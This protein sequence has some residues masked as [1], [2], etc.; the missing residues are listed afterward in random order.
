MD[1]KQD[2]G[3][4]H[5]TTPTPPPPLTH[6]PNFPS[7]HDEGDR[8]SSIDLIQSPQLDAYSVYAPSPSPSVASIHSVHS[9]QSH[10]SH[11]SLHS[12]HFG[13]TFIDSSIPTYHGPQRTFAGFVGSAPIITSPT[14]PDPPFNVSPV[15]P[16]ANASFPQPFIPAP[17]RV[18]VSSIASSHRSMDWSDAHGTP[19]H[20]HPM[21]IQI[22]RENSIHEDMMGSMTPDRMHGHTPDSMKKGQRLDGMESPPAWAEMKTKAGKDRKR[23]PLACIACRRKKIRCSGQKPACKHCLRS[24]VPCVYKVNTR[25]ANPRTDYMAMLDKRLKRMEER[26]VKSIP[27]DHEAASIPRAVLKPTAHSSNSKSPK[28]SKKRAAEDAFGTTHE[29]DGWSKSEP[30]GISYPKVIRIEGV[31]ES[32]MLIEGAAYLPSKDLQIHLAETYFDY[33]YAQSYPLLH[34]PTFMRNLQAGLVPPVLILAVCAVSARFSNHPQLR[35]EPAFL[36]GEEWAAPARE[37]SMKHYDYSNITILTVYLLLG[38]HEFGTCQGG[39][40]WMFGGMA[41]RMALMMQ[42][43]NGGDGYKLRKSDGKERDSR[44]SNTDR[45]NRRRVMWSCFLMDRFTSSGSDRPICFPEEAITVPLPIRDSFYLME[46]EG[47]TETLNGKEAS[48]N[49]SVEPS[50]NCLRAAREKHLGISAHLIR[51]VAIWGRLVNYLNLGGKAREKIPIWNSSSRFQELAQAVNNFIF[52]EELNWNQE[53]L[54]THRAEKVDNQFVLLHIVYQH[55][56]LFLHRFAIPGYGTP[57][58]RGIPQPFLAESQRTAL[59]AANEVSYLVQQAMIS[60]VTAPF[61]GYAAFYS[62]TVHVQGVF[63]KNAQVAERSRK[64]LGTN[65]KFLTQMKRWWGMFH[66]V[67][68][69]LK[70]L[71]RKHV[72]A[73]SSRSGDAP[74]SLDP[75]ER[76]NSTIFQYGD[77]FDRYPNG[78][79]NAE[80]EISGYS[81]E[82]NGINPDLLASEERGNATVQEFFNKFE[83]GNMTIK[84]DSAGCQRMIK[85]GRTDA[86]GK[87]N[88]RPKLTM[89]TNILDLPTHNGTHVPTAATVSIQQQQGQQNFYFT[90]TNVNIPIDSF[91]G[92]TSFLPTANPISSMR[93]PPAQQLPSPSASTPTAT[94]MWTAHYYPEPTSAMAGSTYPFSMSTYTGHGG[95]W[96]MPWNVEPPRSSHGVSHDVLNSPSP[97]GMDPFAIDFE[98]W[99]AVLG[100]GKGHVA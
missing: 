99:T 9:H 60:N 80:Y 86:N 32:S 62:S 6:S 56:R 3:L 90:S 49:S 34:K 24:R 67:A 23:L 84:K 77:W 45:E 87:H 11:H 20:S 55:L 48:S 18:S 79:C 75:E 78:V 97:A 47:N 22:T 14:V 12:P 73:N 13:P 81:N 83:C 76:R 4:Y 52:P 25:K 40:S 51:L 33:V 50:T 88:E 53:N 37:L 17:R 65:I 16:Y 85:K 8:K 71:F 38:L 92:A 36:R 72:D 58:P 44:L 70:D 95:D 21:L 43:H 30:N 61:A 7:Y 28:R 46:I 66:F 59:D 94:D 19:D 96:Y 31:D 29:L 27:K 57:V 2:P 26:V 64:N 10:Q 39:R 15:S 42:L 68:Q 89:N 1:I 54:E 91:A 98:N 100:A 63:A 5:S 41:Q 82:T 35:T 93:P 74:S 69:D